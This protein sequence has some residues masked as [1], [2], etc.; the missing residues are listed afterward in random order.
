MAIEGR[1][2]DGEHCAHARD[3]FLSG[4]RG[5]PWKAREC[6]RPQLQSQSAWTDG[7]RVREVPYVLIL[8]ADP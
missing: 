7:G 3:T 2:D 4:S 5:A 1:T 6:R 8:E